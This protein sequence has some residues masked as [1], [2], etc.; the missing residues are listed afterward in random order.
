LILETILLI[1]MLIL[2]IV[3]ALETREYRQAAKFTQALDAAITG[4][5]ITFTSLVETVKTVEQA[6]NQSIEVHQTMSDQLTILWNIIEVHN[7]ALQLDPL[8]TKI[9][10]NE[11][12]IP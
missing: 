1:V 11:N 6:Y 5:G 4:Y 2:I 10:K 8:L 3:L 7:R 12:K 9:G